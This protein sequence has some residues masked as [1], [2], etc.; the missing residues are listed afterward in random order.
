MLAHATGWLLTGLAFC[1]A[2]YGFAVVIFIWRFKSDASRSP[3]F[4]AVTILKPLHFVE[5]GLKAAIASVLRQD[6]GA[7][8]QL[9]LG[10]QDQRDPAIAVVREIM[11]EHPD[12]DIELVVDGTPHGSN[13]KVSNLINMAAFAKHD[14]LVMS[15]SDITVEPDWLSTVAGHLERDG[16]GAVTCLYAGKARGN[17]WSVVSAMGSTYEFLPNVIGAV[18]LGLAA[19]CFGSTIALTKTTLSR[20]GGLKAFANQLADDYEIGH[21]VRELGL[22]VAIPPFVVDHTSAEKRWTEYFRHEVRWN[23]TTHLIDPIGH[24]ASIIT[25]SLPLALLA[26]PFEHW[27]AFS[28]ALVAATLASRLSVKWCIERK[29]R[30]WA[31]PAWALP[32]R[33]VLAFG[34]FLASFF[35]ENVHWRGS[36][37]VV[38]QSGALSQS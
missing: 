20:I 6:Y 29:F 25:H 38:S 32:I 14:V 18:S 1:G 17:F 2:G 7:P 10:V 22:T 3:T 21:A 34:V 33:D 13:R 8:L 36:R 27:A 35:G 15:D 26:M 28:F 9:I 23:R 24:S 31:G 19:P 37:F 12:A 11:D 30:T 4:R 5:P 16:V